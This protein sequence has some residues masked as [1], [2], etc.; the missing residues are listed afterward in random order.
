MLLQEYGDDRKDDTT[1]ALEDRPAA[2]PVNEE[3]RLNISDV[4][5]EEVLV[6]LDQGEVLELES[7]MIEMP[8][9]LNGIEFDGLGVEESELLKLSDM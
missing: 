6:K 1:V 5:F 3:L 4:D 2:E 8:G 9:I 7:A